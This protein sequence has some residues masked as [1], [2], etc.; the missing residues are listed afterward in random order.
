MKQLGVMPTAIQISISSTG[1][2]IH[3]YTESL[4][5]DNR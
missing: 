4:S 5:H 1:I 3:H 2:K